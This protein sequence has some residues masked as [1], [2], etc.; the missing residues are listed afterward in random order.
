MSQEE[1]NA[2]LTM[3]N[4]MRADIG[5]L[6]QAQQISNFLAVSNNPNVSEDVRNDCL[7]RAMNLMGLYREKSDAQ[8]AYEALAD[9][10]FTL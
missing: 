3:L 5:S 7:N 1:A 9:D 10:P 2:M 6:L 8:K 4:N